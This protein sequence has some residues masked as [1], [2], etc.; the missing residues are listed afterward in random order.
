LKKQGRM[1]FILANLNKMDPIELQSIRDAA[2]DWH[3]TI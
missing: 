3:A 1:S 2:T